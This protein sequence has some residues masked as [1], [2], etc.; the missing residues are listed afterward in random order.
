MFGNKR[1]YVVPL[2][3]I[4]LPVVCGEGDCQ[5][6]NGD[7]GGDRRQRQRYGT[8]GHLGLFLTFLA[9]IMGDAGDGTH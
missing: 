5:Q 2:H 3:L 7:D 8:A 1:L 6:G 4:A 9:A